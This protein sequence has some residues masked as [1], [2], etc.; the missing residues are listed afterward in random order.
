V[1]ISQKRQKAKP[2]TTERRLG[3]PKTSPKRAEFVPANDKAKSAMVAKLVRLSRRAR[4]DYDEFLYVCQQ[5]R[6]KLGLRR[7][8]RQRAL[9]KL[10]SQAEL[11]RFFKVIEDCGDLEHEIMLKLLFYTAVRVSELVQIAVADVDLERSKIFIRRGKGQKDRYI[12]F[13]KSFRLVLKTHLAAHDGCRFLFESR[14]LGPYTTR[15]VQQIVQ[16]YRAQAGLAEKVH[17]HLFRHQMLTFLTSRGLSDAQ[18]Q[19][20]SGHDSKKSLEVYQHLSLA[21]VEAGY[22]AAVAEVGV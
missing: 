19:L 14:R 8:K 15:R 22:Q 4:L 6:R 13:P 2:K 9:P 12:L 21:S 16:Q 3:R 5:A 1:T 17:P 11:K 18:L 20:I 10:L 7:P